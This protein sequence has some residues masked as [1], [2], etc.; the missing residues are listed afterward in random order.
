VCAVCGAA[1]KTRAVHRKHLLTIHTRPGAHVCHA[2][3]RLF[4]TSYAMKRHARMHQL[5]M[6]SVDV[7]AT[8]PATFCRQ[9]AHS[10][11]GGVSAPI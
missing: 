11:N 6:N 10:V 3:G 9:P 7:T 4:N 2:C 5:Q 8:D 1:F